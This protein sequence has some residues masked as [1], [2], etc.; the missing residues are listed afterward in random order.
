MALAASASAAGCRERCGWRLRSPGA[1]RDAG[2]GCRLPTSPRPL[3]NMILEQRKHCW[4]AAA[5]ARGLAIFL[6]PWEGC[7]QTAMNR[8][9]LRAVL[10]DRA[11]QWRP[12]LA[13]RYR[14]TRGATQAACFLVSP[15][16]E[17]SPRVSVFAASDQRED[18]SAAAQAPPLT[19]ATG[20]APPQC[21]LTEE[22]QALVQ[23]LRAKY[24]GGASN[25]G[26]GACGAV[27]CRR[28]QLPGLSQPATAS[29]RGLCC[30]AH[31]CCSRSPYLTLQAL[32]PSPPSQV[33]ALHRLHA[34]PV[35]P[36][37]AAC[38]SPAMAPAQPQSATTTG[39]CRGPAATAGAPVCSH[40]QTLAQR[41][42]QEAHWQPGR[43]PMA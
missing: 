17:I 16:K 21:S 32:L 22:E 40:S 9:E 29:S 15:S 4:V 24:C 12:S 36:M 38:A 26:A 20:E 11:M 34:V 28:H 1:A 6:C 3:P 14:S 33:P 5:A 42:A 2:P 25:K 27:L 41:Q 23:L 7:V 8:Q 31:H 43:P 39:S 18:M 19:M 37:T 10:N 13:E 30:W 35:P